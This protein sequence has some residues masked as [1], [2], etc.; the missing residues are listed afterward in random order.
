MFWFA[1]SFFCYTCRFFFF[2]SLF[3]FQ[4]VEKTAK[5]ISERRSQEHYKNKVPINI[6]E[7]EAGQLA[8]TITEQAQLKK[9]IQLLQQFLN[10]RPPK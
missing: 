8:D 9:D 7:K 6:Q 4:A 3:F 10:Q 1:L 2:F 5:T